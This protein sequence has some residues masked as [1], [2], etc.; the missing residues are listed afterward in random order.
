MKTPKSPRPFKARPPP[1]G[2]AVDRI[3]FG[4]IAV[5]VVYAMWSV[6]GAISRLP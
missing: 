2:P 4:W 6:L 1:L 5:L 3:V